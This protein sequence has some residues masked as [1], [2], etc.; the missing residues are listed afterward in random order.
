MHE[1]Y[2]E[3]AVRNVTG[4][5]CRKTFLAAYFFIEFNIF[6]VKYMTF[7]KA[8]GYL[9]DR[10]GLNGINISEACKVRSWKK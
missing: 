10:R 4:S 5:N 2:F 8:N 3:Y 7:E 9:K 6:D 1:K